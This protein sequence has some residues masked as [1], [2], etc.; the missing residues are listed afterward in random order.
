MIRLDYFV[1]ALLFLIFCGQVGAAESLFIRYD[2]G[3]DREAVRIIGVDDKAQEFLLI[4]KSFLSKRK[5][6]F[7]PNRSKYE[8]YVVVDAIQKKVLPFMT[9][10]VNEAISFGGAARVPDGYIIPVTR[11]KKRIELYRY[12]R[13]K[14]SI[15]KFYDTLVP[16]QIA[17][18]NDIHATTNGY[19]TVSAK[20]DSMVV[21]FYPYDDSGGRILS[22]LPPGD[23]I[24]SINDII[25]LNDVIYFSGVGQSDISG[26]YLW[27]ASINLLKSEDVVLSYRVHVE[28]GR[29][30]SAKFVRSYHGM[31]S[32]IISERQS[33]FSPPV[34]SIVQLGDNPVH[35]WE[36][37]TSDIQGDKDY[38]AAWVCGNKLL[39][40]KKNKSKSKKTIVKVWNLA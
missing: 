11:E 26:R 27:V 18:L 16:K 28:A 17:N 38:F 22:L 23:A 33:S 30:M 32:I 37:S 31:P 1:W 6:S 21:S 12:D 14:G 25:K 19:V 35:V 39:L 3:T 7:D 5:A 15:Q 24:V 13:R 10:D 40:A 36:E 4:E 2:P 29:I 9:A 20:R 34:V 8:I